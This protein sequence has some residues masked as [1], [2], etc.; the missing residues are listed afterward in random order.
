MSEVERI[1]LP[2][3]GAAA[4]HVHSCLF[5]VSPELTLDRRNESPIRE[6]CVENY[7]SQTSLLERQNVSADWKFQ[8]YD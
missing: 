8:D 3:C 1:N 7:I 4:R 5:V 6:K 2:C